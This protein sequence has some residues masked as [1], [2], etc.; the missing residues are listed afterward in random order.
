QLLA[1]SSDVEGDVSLQGVSYS[2]SDGT[3]SANDDG[4]FSFIPNENF[5]GDI[6]LDVV[7]LDAEGASD[8]AQAN[9]VVVP[10]NDAP[11]A[12]NVG[13][14]TTNEDNSIEIDPDYIL[15]FASD[16]DGDDLSLASLTLRDPN[17][18]T[19]TQNTQTGVYSFS[20]A[21]NFAGAVALD[22]LINDG[23][24]DTAGSMEVNV[25]PVNDA[26]FVDGNSH[27]TVMED[28][29]ITFNA[30]DLL[31]LFGD[32]DGDNL[33]ISNVIIADGD[34]AEGQVVANGD[35]TFTFTPEDDFAGT[36]QLQVIVSDGTVETAMDMPVYVRPVADGAVITKSQDGPIVMNEDETGFLSLSVDL[37]DAS[38]SLTSLVMTGYPLGFT[39]SDGEHS[40]T[41]TEEGQLILINDWD[42]S[43]ISIDPPENWH[44]T[45]EVTLTATTVDYG[46]ENSNALPDSSDITGD[47]DATEGQDLIITELDLLDMAENT[48]VQDGDEPG[49]VHLINNS[50]GELVDNG[51][52][53]W[54]FSP[55]D[56]FTGEVDFAY[57]IQR[58]GE[59]FDEQSSIGVQPAVP[60][61]DNGLEIE[62][63]ATTD[64]D[65]GNSVEFTDADLLAQINGVD[66]ND[67]SITGVQITDGV[68]VLR[69][70]SDGTYTYTPDP[71]FSS[72]AQI[73]FVAS[74]DL[75]SVT[76]FVNVNV[77]N[78]APEV[79]AVDQASNYTVAEDGSI[80]F[81]E[82]ELLTA[83]G[84]TDADGDT[85]TV[86]GLGVQPDSG[87]VINNGDGSWTVWP[88]SDF[89]GNMELT[90][91]VNDGTYST[92][93]TVLLTVTP[94]NDV[95]TESTPL[96]VEM[97]MNGTT[98]LTLDELLANVTDVD[99]DTLSVSN[100]Q[101]DNATVTDNGD[102]SYSIVAD[103]DFQ[104]T[105]GIT[106]DVSDGTETIQASIS[107]NVS[108]A[109][110]GQ[111]DGE[112]ADYTVSPGGSLNI[113]MP[114]S[115]S[116]DDSVDH[117]IASDLPDGA[118]ISNGLEDNDGNYVIS[119]DLS[120][121]IQVSLG[122]GFEGDVSINVIGYDALDQTVDGASEIISVEVDDA[123]AAQGS[124]ADGANVNAGSDDQGGGD[125]TNADNTNA[126]VDV[127]DDS[128]SFDNANDNNGS[129][130]DMSDLG[131]IG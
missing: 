52:G 129:N 80:T 131:G 84:A 76:S 97:N 86:E 100:F 25:I 5:N 29:Q 71:D 56:G 82:S 2:G 53:T 128:S 59:L 43:N 101:S 42:I 58:D 98:T 102:D 17:H 83:V 88:D 110:D 60:G 23:T 12:G 127:M 119:G 120:Q 78:A 96:Y 54:T 30:D 44:G 114:S 7:V 64:I 46:D 113:A 20:P 67:L 109:E 107:A 66:G 95:P 22:Y 32:V 27:A 123:Y 3:L 73:S 121:P 93:A 18:G 124:S 105:A 72:E 35:G 48:Q 61:A 11:Q 85:M 112:A 74:D 99:G 79:V 26:A 81:T 34:E 37:L 125:W 19:L 28:G 94:E 6:V 63:I 115:I 108:P 10:V 69:Q 16:V 36:T 8:T 92:P 117:V 38:E 68:G 24:V 14:L 65:K 50:Q 13:T 47:F 1:N 91:M 31:N 21:A 15:G 9:I 118:T 111:V 106:Y 45:F 51:D 41:I 57:V 33:T 39:I 75:N 87:T 4:S 103:G 77:I 70:S 89:G 40:V 90:Y 62:G 116:E 55:A 130:D 122:D 104:G 49:F 126:G